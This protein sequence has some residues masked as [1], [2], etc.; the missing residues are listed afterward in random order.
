MSEQSENWHLDKKVPIT[1]IIAMVAQLVAF[2]WYAG[3]L[4]LRIE[5]VVVENAAQSQRIAEVEKTGQ[6]RD[7][8]AATIAAQL[9]ALTASVADLKSAQN[10]T[11]QLL[12]EFLRSTP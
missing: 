6:V 8:T 10:Q 1:L 9:N 7:V 5:A 11:N 12:Q 4:N 3:Q 2:G